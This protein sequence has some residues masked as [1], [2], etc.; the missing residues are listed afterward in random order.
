MI[1][2]IIFTRFRREKSDP[3]K[4]NENNIHP[5]ETPDDVRPNIRAVWIIEEGTAE[6]G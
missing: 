1:L 3:E 4:C 2:A 5:I 6:P